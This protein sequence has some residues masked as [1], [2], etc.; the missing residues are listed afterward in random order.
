MPRLIWL[1]LALVLIV[2]PEPAFAERRVALIVGNGAYTA[3]GPLANPANDANDMAAA[4][5]KKQQT[6][7][8]A[9]QP[10]SPKKGGVTR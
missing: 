9:R 1:C 2:T 5:R 8:P 6:S 10:V 7:R 3:A 4:L